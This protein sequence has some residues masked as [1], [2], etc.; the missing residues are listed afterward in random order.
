M[1]DKYSVGSTAYL[2]TSLIKTSSLKN[3]NE[4]LL[5]YGVCYSAFMQYRP[6]YKSTLYVV[7]LNDPTILT[8]NDVRDVGTTGARDQIYA[9]M[10]TPKT[11]SILFWYDRGENTKSCQ[12]TAATA[13]VCDNRKSA[14]IVCKLL[15]KYTFSEDIS[16]GDFNT[17]IRSELMTKLI[18]LLK[19][20]K[21]G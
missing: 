18:T 7:Y 12:E 17:S 21:H 14:E 10:N 11:S 1:T 4:Q 16:V 5:K 9:R 6:N 8:F 2:L 15:K 3:L 19:R 13:F 20:Q